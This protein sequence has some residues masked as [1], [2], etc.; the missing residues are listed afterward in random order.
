MDMAEYT[1]ICLNM[2]VRE[3]AQICLNGF[4]FIFP[5]CNALSTSTR[6]CLFQHLHKTKT[7]SV[8][9]NGAVFL[10]TQTLIFV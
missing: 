5:Y 1:W 2:P 7:F 6:A 9:E 8:K 10:E 3:Y 4:R